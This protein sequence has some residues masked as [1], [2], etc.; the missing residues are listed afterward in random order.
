MLNT[1]QRCWQLGIHCRPMR[2]DSAAYW[3]ENGMI[4]LLE[5]E[6]FGFKGDVVET[7][8]IPLHQICAIRNSRNGCWVHV[9][10]MTSNS[11]PMAL[12]SKIAFTELN[13]LFGQQPPNS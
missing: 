3:L 7:Y 2:F 12:K 6:Y 11:R 4:K 9:V 1:F 5:V 13:A 8:Y 10:G